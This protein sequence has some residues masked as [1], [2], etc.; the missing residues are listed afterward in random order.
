[1]WIIFSGSG[2]D[3]FKNFEQTNLRYIDRAV[4]IAAHSNRSLLVVEIVFERRHN[5]TSK[6]A[7]DMMS[8]RTAAALQ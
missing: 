5:M 3:G 2:N 4:H 7:V 6:S 8:Y 1:M